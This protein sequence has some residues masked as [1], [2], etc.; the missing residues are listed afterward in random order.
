M[1][2][3]DPDIQVP[4]SQTWS[5]G[6]QRA[7]DRNI[8]DRSPLRRHARRAGVD[9]TSNYNEINIVENGFLNEFKLAQANLQAN[10]AAG[11]GTT[12]RYFGPGTDTSPL[13]IY[14]AY[15]SGTPTSQA[16]TRRSTR[17]RCSP[18][19]PMSIRWP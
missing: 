4:Y 13:P 10:I 2:D 14:L 16:A 7:L 1:N 6:V 12:F 17:R 11:R 5:L 3:F 9:R 18:T 8:G 15:F 19:A